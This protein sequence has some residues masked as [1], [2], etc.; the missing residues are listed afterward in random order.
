MRSPLGRDQEGVEVVNEFFGTSEPLAE[1]WGWWR[2]GWR[3]GWGGRRGAAVAV[4]RQGCVCP[5]AAQVPAVLGVHGQF[6][7][8]VLDISVVLRE[9]Y[10]QCK[11][12][13]RLFLR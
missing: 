12:C 3:R 8:R 2:L 10:P 11:L 5:L 4:H 6:I 1:R 9:G 13:R 7:D